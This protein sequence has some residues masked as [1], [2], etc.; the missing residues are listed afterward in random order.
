[1][2][3]CIIAGSGDL[4][5]KIAQTH[6]KNGGEVF[7]AIISNDNNVD[8]TDFDNEKFQLGEINRLFSALKTRNIKDIVMIG[9]IKKPNLLNLKVDKIAALLVAKILKN[10]FLGDDKLLRTISDF[11]K[12]YG[13]NILSPMSILSKEYT[14]KEGVITDFKPSEEE[15]SNILNIGKIEALKLGALDLGQAVIIK[16][17]KLIATENEDGTDELIKKHGCENAILVKFMKPIQDDK[18]DIPT[19]GEETVKMVAKYKMSGI[20]IEAEKVMIVNISEVTNLA[21]NLRIFIIGIK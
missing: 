9:G 1:M 3:L 4:P 6:V 12:D 7:L 20:A 2:K 17:N 13:F 16:G 5:K 11:M 21:N 8:Y 14:I 15:I 10:K 18:L 19:I